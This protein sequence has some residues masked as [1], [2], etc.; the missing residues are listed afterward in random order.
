V[1]A[2]FSHDS[3][4]LRGSLAVRLRAAA[5]PA[6]HTDPG[7]KVTVKVGDKEFG[8]VIAPAD[9]NVRVPVVVPPGIAFAL[10]RSVNRH[11]KASQQFLDLK[12]P[13]AQRALVVAPEKLAA[14]SAAEVAV[15]AVD[16]NGRD[17]STHPRSSWHRRGR[18]PSPWAASPGGGPIP[19]ARA[20][21]PAR[22]DS[23]PH[24]VA[25][26]TATT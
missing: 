1:V 26:R 11:G 19:G 13:P 14:G 21:L 25:A 17:W 9:G 12:I 22:P 20:G 24:C 6:F 4:I 7:A 15:L 10:A 2:D 8:P 23:P 5:S 18:G 3:L 16:P